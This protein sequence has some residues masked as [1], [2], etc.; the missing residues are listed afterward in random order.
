MHPPL[1]SKER[2]TLLALQ[3]STRTRRRG[4]ASAGVSERRRF[5]VS[6]DQKLRAPLHNISGYAQLLEAGIRGPLTRQQRTD[7]GR[8]RANE[9]NLARL[10][11]AVMRFARWYDDDRPPLEDVVLRDALRAANRQIA[12]S[13]R[14]KGITCHRDLKT[15]P[16]GLTVRAEPRRLVEIIRQLL[17]NAVKF[18]RPGGVITVRT[19]SAR[20]IVALEI[21]D[22]GIGIDKADIELIFQPFVRGRCAYVRAQ[23]GVGLGLAITRALAHSIDGELSV[24]SRRGAGSTF[25]LDLQSAGV[26]RP[27]P[28]G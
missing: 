15:L 17:E 28:A 13:A 19:T 26:L 7:I 27:R 18:S 16:A 21:A 8:I 4:P 5:L 11:R 25:R 23:E 12:A 14:L 22:T 2:S 3:K 20:N 24:R 6:L 10:V 1:F 9:R